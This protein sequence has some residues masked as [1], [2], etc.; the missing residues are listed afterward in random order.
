MDSLLCDIRTLSIYRLFVITV[1]YVQYNK[2]N[3][4][5][6]RWQRVAFNT[7]VSSWQP[8]NYINVRVVFRHLHPLIVQLRN[9]DLCCKAQT[10]FFIK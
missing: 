6:R 3:V 5:E 4:R 2:Y 10:E 9:V 7:E 8:Y 1:Y